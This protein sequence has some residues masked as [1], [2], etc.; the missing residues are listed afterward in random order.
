MSRVD[1]EKPETINNDVLVQTSRFIEEINQKIKDDDYT[2]HWNA[3]DCLRNK[4]IF[5]QGVRSRVTRGIAILEKIE[6]SS[7][8]EQNSTAHHMS[9]EIKNYLL[10]EQINMEKI[11][12]REEDIIISPSDIG[13]HN[14]LRSKS[15]IIKFIDFEYSGLDDIAKLA[16]DM[17]LQPNSVL[18]REK[19]EL[20]IEELENRELNTS[21]GWLKRVRILLP[22]LRIKWITIMLNNL[23][24][25][26]F[27]MQLENI[28]KY[29]F[30]TDSTVLFLD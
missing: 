6:T 9:K 15:G 25:T 5:E 18:S 14:M 17:I 21:E 19:T 2:Y 10:N 26:R 22:I 7:M 29:K 28:V 3:K 1:G 8:N 24:N 12:V 16:C 23:K 27:E 11:D 30:K 13:I 4:K 20:W